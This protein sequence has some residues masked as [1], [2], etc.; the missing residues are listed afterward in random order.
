M[1]TIKVVF[2]AAVVAMIAA[3]LC[4]GIAMTL[5]NVPES[6]GMNIFQA[7]KIGRKFMLAATFLFSPGLVAFILTAASKES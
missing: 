2:I 6:F 4:F 1:R 7:D 5:V 3:F